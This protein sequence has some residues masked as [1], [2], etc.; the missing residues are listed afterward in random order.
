MAVA[1]PMRSLGLTVKISLLFAV[2]GLAAGLGLFS[3]LR[4]LDDVR[5]ID[6]KAM[7]DLALAN[8]ASLLANRVAQTSLLSR[9]DEAAGDRAVELALDHLDGAVELADSA[10]ANLISALPAAMKPRIR[11]SI[12]SIR[13]FIAFQRDIVTMG[14]LRLAQGRAGR[15][16]RRRRPRECPPD[17]RR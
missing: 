10:R 13:T 16:G 1:E 14:R 3:A 4:G 9:F 12:P 11:R 5:A 7:A 8:Q 2:L 15:G 17:H 6:G